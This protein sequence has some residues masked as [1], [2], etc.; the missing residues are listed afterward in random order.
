MKWLPV[1]IEGEYRIDLV[2]RST[3]ES[4]RN[5]IRH[6]LMQAAHE[7]GLTVTPYDRHLFGWHSLW[8]WEIALLSVVRGVLHGLR[9]RCHCADDV[10][11]AE[12]TEGL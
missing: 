2:Y 8:L 10:A 11:W 4:V 6:N 12:I 5:S 9:R 7:Q 3:S 1:V